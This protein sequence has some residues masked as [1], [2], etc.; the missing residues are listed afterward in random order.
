MT[1][2][3]QVK[4]V[5]S[6]SYTITSDKGGI[7]GTLQGFTPSST[8]PLQRIHEIAQRTPDNITDTIEIVP[9]RTEFTITVDRLETYDKA[10]MEALGFPNFEDL[11]QIVAPITINE[12]WIDSLGNT[13][14]IQYIDCWVA[15]WNKTIREGTTTVTETVTLNPTRIKV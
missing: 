12:T 1:R 13:R 2:V 6:Y 9:G 14:T 11:T 7:L 15:S 3:P 8:R 10:M 4:S 5:V